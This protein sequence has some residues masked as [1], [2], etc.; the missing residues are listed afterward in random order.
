MANHTL[1]AQWDVGATLWCAIFNEAGQVWDFTATSFKALASAAN[2]S[3]ALTADATE[4]E[5]YRATVDMNTLNSGGGPTTYDIRYYEQVGGSP[6]LADDDIGG[7]SIIVRFGVKAETTSKPKVVANIVADGADVEIQAWLELDGAIVDLDTEDASAT[8]DV[9]VREFDA[10]ANLF[11]VDS[12][13][14]AA[15][16]LSANVA[17]HFELEKAS[18]ITSALDD[19][20]LFM[21]VQI[22]ENSN[23]WTL[24]KPI[25]VFGGS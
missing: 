24:L 17:N 2:F 18:V 12:A 22:V 8:C 15:F 6:D 19:S 20:A 1:R 11:Q 4:T 5:H 21:Q 23:T 14:N 25:A 13:D 10:G 16:A 3:Q 9:Q 7:E